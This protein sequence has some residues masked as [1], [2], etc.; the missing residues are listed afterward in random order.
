MLE[1]CTPGCFQDA[2]A[3][4]VALHNDNHNRFMRMSDRTFEPRIPRRFLETLL[5]FFVELFE[6]AHGKL[7]I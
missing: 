5:F 2:G 3:G 1:S 6:D 7:V 4:N